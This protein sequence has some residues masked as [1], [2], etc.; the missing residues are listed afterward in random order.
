[1]MFILIDLF[2]DSN[3]LQEACKA[4]VTRLRKNQMES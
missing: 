2:D 4:R 1:M 3:D